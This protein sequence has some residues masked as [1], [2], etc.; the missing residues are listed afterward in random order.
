MKKL[1]DVALDLLKRA[2]FANA[3]READSACLFFA[4]QPEMPE[5]VRKLKGRK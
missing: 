2:A 1:N 5:K 3:K 4:Y